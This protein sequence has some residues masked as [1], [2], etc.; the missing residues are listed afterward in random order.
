MINAWG[1]YVLPDAGD[2]EATKLMDKK[3]IKILE[4]FSAERPVTAVFVTNVKSFVLKHPKKSSP[5]TMARDD[6]D[7][8]GALKVPLPNYLVKDLRDHVHLRFLF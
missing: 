6:V 4:P 5:F 2:V 7:W 8:Q 1:A 3:K